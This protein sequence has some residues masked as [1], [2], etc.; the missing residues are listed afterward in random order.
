MNCG[1]TAN[2]DDVASINIE[3]AGHA[4]IACQVNG[5]ACVLRLDRETWTQPGQV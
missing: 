5:T 1:Y 4:R 2:A 3:R